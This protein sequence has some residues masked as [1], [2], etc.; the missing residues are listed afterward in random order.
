VEADNPYGYARELAEIVG[1]IKKRNTKNVLFITGDKHFSNLFAYDVDRDGKPD[2][3]EANIGPLRAGVAS[4]KGLI[5]QSLNPQQLATYA[6]RD[7]FA[8]GRLQIDHS[9]RLA[10]E[11]RDVEGRT[12]PGGLLRLDPLKPDPN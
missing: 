3:H 8:Y 7:R 4:G 1:H 9:G 10:V 11:I 12:V 6:G 5:D 2:F